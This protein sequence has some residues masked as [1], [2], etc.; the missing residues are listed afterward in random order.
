LV[1]VRH[2]DD[3][4]GAIGLVPRMLVGIVILREAAAT[5]TRVTPIRKQPVNMVRALPCQSST[6]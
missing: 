4:K 2:Q 5:L 1:V 6:L 3:L